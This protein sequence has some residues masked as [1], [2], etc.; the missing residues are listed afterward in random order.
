MFR[1]LLLY[2]VWR[3]SM[4]HLSEWAATRNLPALE[5]RETAVY[6]TI[7]AHRHGQHIP[8]EGWVLIAHFW[9]PSPS[10]WN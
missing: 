9:G 1:G 5:S 2:S 10:E 4:T 3:R 6:L 8:L 7:L